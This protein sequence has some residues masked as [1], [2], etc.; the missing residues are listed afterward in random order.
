ML[1]E[2]FLTHM[3]TTRGGTL[4]RQEWDAAVRETKA[5]ISQ[6]RPEDQAMASRAFSD[7]LLE[8]GARAGFIEPPE[9]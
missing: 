1:F 6:V 8:Y 9:F 3:P 7:T 4:T 5:L 2:Q